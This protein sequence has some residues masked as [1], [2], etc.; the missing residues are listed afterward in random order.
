MRPHPASKPKQAADWDDKRPAASPYA[1]IASLIRQLV[2][3]DALNRE[4]Q[5]VQ[6]EQV[7]SDV[8]VDGFR[9][10]LVRLPRSNQASVTLSPREQEIVR[11]VAQG[12]P[13]KV[14]AAVLNIS[15]WTVCTHLRRIFAKLG[16]G[17]RAAMVARLLHGGNVQPRAQADKQTS[18]AG[19]V[20][21][22]PASAHVSK[23]K[24]ETATH[25][26]RSLAVSGG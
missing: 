12:H 20:A 22:G 9:Y 19:P 11:M 10:L 25:R 4:T 7:I 16:V 15:S 13:N 26:Q 3:T 14:I 5:D 21:F 8:E 2:T 18:L 23:T 1:V 6:T 24:V 17:S